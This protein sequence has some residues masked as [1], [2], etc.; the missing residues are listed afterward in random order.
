MELRK[1][2]VAQAVAR[3]WCSEK[4]S[5]KTMDSDLAMAIT[6]EVMALG[7]FRTL[8]IEKELAR[9]Y[10]NCDDNRLKL[11]LLLESHCIRNTIENMKK[12]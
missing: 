12:G 6:E 8:I 2:E 1:E 9:I 4:N 10:D 3:G 11:D 5:S 7:I